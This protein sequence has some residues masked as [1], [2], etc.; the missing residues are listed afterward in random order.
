MQEKIRPQHGGGGGIVE[1]RN[2]ARVD[3]RMGDV[4]GRN[5]Q[6]VADAVVDRQPAVDFPVVLD[7]G[8]EVGAPPVSYAVSPDVVTMIVESSLRV[9]ID[10]AE[11]HVRQGISVV[12]GPEL[13]KL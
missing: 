8:L 10:V 1:G 13:A 7:I 12:K 11:E 3:R 9:T 6:V 5:Q 2:E 4:M